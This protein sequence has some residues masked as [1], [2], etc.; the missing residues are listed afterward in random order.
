MPYICHDFLT[1]Q[2]REILTA[3]SSVIESKRDGLDA[4]I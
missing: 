3:P 2:I 4:Q 1:S